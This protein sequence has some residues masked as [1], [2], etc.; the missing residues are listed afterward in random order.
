MQ[1][2]TP[3][4]DYVQ[5]FAGFGQHRLN[6]G[7]VLDATQD[8]IAVSGADLRAAANAAEHMRRGYKYTQGEENP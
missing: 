2:G 5:A 6:A 3:G 1:P 7:Q 8:H 4:R